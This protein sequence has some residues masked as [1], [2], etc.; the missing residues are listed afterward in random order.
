M[1]HAQKSSIQS[2]RSESQL[3]E[4]LRSPNAYPH[5]DADSVEVHQTHISWVYLIGDYGFKLKKP[6]R[7]SFLDYSTL[8]KRKHFCEEEVRLDRRYAPDLYL[9]VVPIRMI[10][11]RPF[12]EQM[13]EGVSGGP[14]EIVDY[15]VK[16]RRFPDDALLSRRMRSGTLTTQEVFSLAELVADFHQSATRL[17]VK[18][19]DNRLG[20]VDRVYQDAA[21]NLRSLADEVSGQSARTVQVLTRWT[22]DYFDDHR[23]VFLQRVANGFIRECHGDMHLANIVYWKDRLIPFDGIEFNETFRWIDVISDAAFVAM[24][25]AARGRLDLCRSFINAYLER[26]GDHA[27]LA[28]LR[29]YLVYRA[30]TRAKISAMRAAQPGLAD[31][32]RKSAMEDCRQQVELAYRFSLRDE[33][34]LWITHGVSGSGKTKISELVVQRRGA[35][36][37]RSDLE[38]KR[39]FGL[40]PMLRPSRDQHKTLYCDS[41][42]HATYA[43]LRQLSRCILRAGYPV[44]VDATFLKEDERTIFRNLA[45]R[46]G[47]TFGILDCHADQVTL[48]QRVADRMAR[49]DDA[50]DADIAVLEHQLACHEPLSVNESAEVVQIP[51]PVISIDSMK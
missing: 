32:Q 19:S 51:D 46:E 21:D 2:G 7:T 33:A 8:E 26:T 18:I 22:R 4:G 36:R 11:G 6:I 15:A 29:W 37:L 40:T 47:A 41:A 50:S 34:A 20:S 3:I 1:S 44:V 13:P 24:D 35:I 16:M 30:L 25:L 31:L 48:H 12:V 17:D 10:D 49:G 27:S 5:I 23:R 43:R 38:R 9:A 45:R 42:H 28:V 14:G 39:H